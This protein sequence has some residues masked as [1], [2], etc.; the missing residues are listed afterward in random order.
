MAGEL[1]KA[2]VFLRGRCEELKPGTFNGLNGP[3]AAASCLQKFFIG[4][5]EVR[6][7]CDRC[8]SA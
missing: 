1:V 8:F 2:G 5:A 3:Q 7:E 6:L 4:Q